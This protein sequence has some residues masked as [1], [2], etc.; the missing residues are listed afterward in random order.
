MGIHLSWDNA[1]NVEVELAEILARQ[2]QYGWLV[3]R[4]KAEELVSW[5][6]AEEERLSNNIHPHLPK[7]IKKGHEL[8]SIFKAD[9]SY[10]SHAISWL[11][12]VG[13]DSSS[14]VLSGPF[15]RIS[16]NDPS[17][18]SGDQIKR[19]LFSLG[20]VPDQWNYKKDPKTKKFLYDD[21]RELI[22]TS[23][24]LTESSLESITGDE[25]WGVDLVQL[26]KVQ[27]RKKFFVGG[28]YFED[29]DG[30]GEVEKGLLSRIRP[31]N[32]I[33]SEVVQCGT[34]TGRAQHRGVA[35]V[36]RPGSFLGTETRELFIARPGKV[37]VG[38]DYSQLESRVA[39]EIIYRYTKFKSGIGDL[40][41]ADLILNSED[42]HTYTLNSLNGL[43]SSRNRA[44]T[45]TYALMFGAQERKLGSICDLKPIKWTDVRAG[46]EVL[47]LLKESFPG[48]IEARDATIEQAKSGWLPGLDGRKI[49]VR[50][51]H[52]AFNAKVQ[53]WGSQIVKMGIILN[54]RK[55][56]EFSLN[57]QQVSWVHDEW[58]SET[59]PQI[60]EDTR[61]IALESVVESGKIYD[62]TVDMAGD[63]KIGLSWGEI[64]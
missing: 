40:R 35:N 32:T 13:Y 38:T 56:E 27:A 24:K 60:A 4:E 17:L 51:P 41:Y 37:L 18:T 26:L 52:S 3:D 1:Y 11:A 34:N 53:G 63:S 42:V 61:R 48:L 44:K 39:A 16:Y 50:S 23:P 36:P 10:T 5:L 49:F 47:N 12:N 21:N 22:P 62:F 46:E 7:V 15:S 57:Q 28:D 33:A 64:H 58:T 59:D 31:D 14:R 45:I 29:E 2:E 6:L 55:K 30:N 25:T 54:N 9:G 8:K 43:I 20:W 19:A